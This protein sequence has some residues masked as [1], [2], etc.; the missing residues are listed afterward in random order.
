MSLSSLKTDDLIFGFGKNSKWL[1]VNI[2]LAK[3]FIWVF[4]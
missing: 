1:L 4:L 2:Q 3:E